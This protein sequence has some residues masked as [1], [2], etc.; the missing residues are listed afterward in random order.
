MENGMLK[1]KMSDIFRSNLLRQK[2]GN[3]QGEVQG[4]LFGQL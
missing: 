2:R 4:V 1:L 3:L